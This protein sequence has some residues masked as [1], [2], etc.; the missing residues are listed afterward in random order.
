MHLITTM[1]QQRGI[2][3]KYNKWVSKDKVRK[4]LA[5]FHFFI[6]NKIEKLMRLI[7][8]FLNIVNDTTF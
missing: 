4:L 1:N 2:E 3:A 8:N 5:F 7:Q 6:Y